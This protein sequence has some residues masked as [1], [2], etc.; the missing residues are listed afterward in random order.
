M[1]SVESTTV[2][3]PENI[4]G[5]PE[6][7]HKLANSFEDSSVGL[8]ALGDLMIKAKNEPLDEGTF[9]GIGYLLII[10]SENLIQHCFAALDLA[11]E[12][13]KLKLDKE[14]VSMQNDTDVHQSTT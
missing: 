3:Y 9:E 7:Y 11:T 8:A 6:S 13:D 14:P 12:A 2:S 1:N 5:T 10:L 4:P